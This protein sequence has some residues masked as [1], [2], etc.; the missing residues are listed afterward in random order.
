MRITP[1][2]GKSS[3]GFVDFPDAPRACHNLVAGRFAPASGKS[4]EIACP[5]DGRRVGAVSMS[6]TAEVDAAVAAA[7][8]AWPAWRAMPLKERSQPLFRL[9]ELLTRHLE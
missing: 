5:Y 4:L 7:A 9:R 1:I 3:Q 6:T 8:A 2:G